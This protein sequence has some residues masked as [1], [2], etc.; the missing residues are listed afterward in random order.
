MHDIRY[1]AYGTKKYRVHAKWTRERNGDVHVVHMALCGKFISFIRLL[2]PGQS[3][4]GLNDWHVFSII[5]ILLTNIITTGAGRIGQSF[6]E[7]D[8]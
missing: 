5:N 4:T 2:Y 3:Q 1:D 8:H 7:R 6:S